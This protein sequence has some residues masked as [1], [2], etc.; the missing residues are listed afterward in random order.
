MTMTATS[1]SK[2]QTPA[3]QSQP[4]AKMDSLL[5]EQIYHRHYKN[6]YNYIGFRIN[7]H[8]DAEELASQ[9][10]E[11]AMVSWHRYNE[12][13]PVEA[14]LIGIAKNTVTDYLRA[15]KRKY[16]I[17]LDSIL[18][19]KAVNRQPQEVVVKNE[20]N[21]ALLTAMSKLKEQERQILAMKFAT[22]LKHEEIATVMGISVSNVGVIVHRALKKLRERMEE[23]T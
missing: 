14:W 22:D 19:L 4:L 6:V 16:F 15:K 18:G 7:N 17:P 5:L 8:H 20:E 12:A 9:V 2:T 13:L 10:F 1:N 11:K 23:I 21:R 3:V